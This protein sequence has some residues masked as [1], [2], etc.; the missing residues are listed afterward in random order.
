MRELTDADYEKLKSAPSVRAGLAGIETSRQ[1]ASRRFWIVMPIGAA[2]LAGQFYFFYQQD[3][4]IVGVVIL[5]LGGLATWVTAN[6]G[7]MKVNEQLKSGILTEAARMAGLRYALQAAEHPV[8]DEA[9]PFL[10]SSEGRPSITDLFEAELEGE[11]KVAIFEMGLSHKTGNDD[12]EK[13]VTDFSG[14]M[15][16]FSRTAPGE[17]VVAVRPSGGLLG[18]ILSMA[19]SVEFPGFKASTRKVELGEDPPFESAFDIQATDPELAR[20]VLTPEI[21]RLLLELRGTERIWFYCGPRNILIGLWGADR[22]EGGSMLRN[23]PIEERV[24]KMVDDLNAS[25]RTMHRLLE[26]A[27]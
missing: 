9:Q 19:V 2:I 11:R 16:A 7:L 1:A 14:Q 24:R 5:M 6:W 4:A 3:L 25:I 18:S 8:M 23:R 22:F 21:R 12:N 10:F 17:G 26:I 20:A 13:T 27:G 15:F